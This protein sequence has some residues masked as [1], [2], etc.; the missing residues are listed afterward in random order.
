MAGFIRCASVEEIKG[1]VQ[2][3]CDAFLDDN[4]RFIL[5]G[6]I[7]GNLPLLNA[8]L[9]GQLLLGHFLVLACGIKP[10]GKAAHAIGSCSSNNYSKTNF[11]YIYF[12]IS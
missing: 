4:W 12:T 7:E 1:D 11:I 6:F 3:F 8:K 10:L 2:K 9:I 5:I